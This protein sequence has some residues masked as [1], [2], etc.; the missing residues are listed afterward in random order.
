MLQ[1][2]LGINREDIYSVRIHDKYSFI[3]LSEPHAELAIA[4]LNGMEFKG[5]IAAVSYSNK[6]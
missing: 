5:R 1:T 2:E 3:T 4:K 6:E